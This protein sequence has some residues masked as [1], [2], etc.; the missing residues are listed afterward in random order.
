[1]D[2]STTMRLRREYPL[3]S[4]CVYLNSCSMGAVPRGARTAAARYFDAVEQ[5]RDRVF[6]DLFAEVT[7]Y[8]DG[9]AELIGAA[10]GSVA[11]DV[12]V[13]ALLGRVL[14]ALPWS[15]RPRAITTDLE[16]PSVRFL[17]NAFRRYGCEPHVVPSRDGVTIDVERVVEAI[18]ERTRVVVL[19]HVT[20]ATGALVDVAPI[21]ARA[22]E[23]GALVVLDA[24]QSIG[25]VPVDVERMGV[26]VVLGGAHKWLC[27]A[28]DLAFAWVEPSLLAT[29]EPAAT[30]W[31]ASRDPL[32]FAHAEGWGEGA[33]RL[34]AGTPALVPAITSREGLRLVRELGASA[35]RARSLAMTARIFDHADV[36]GIQTLTP[37]AD[38]ARG[39]VVSLRVPD[40]ARAVADL[41]AA[42]FVCSYRN[43]LR[44]A[45][46]FYNTDDEIDAM[47][48]AVVERARKLS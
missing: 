27:G 24:Y 44:L 18:D 47:M 23:R 12:S 39:G 20:F 8:A 2:A 42:G 31:M 43:G 17:L 32:S 22:R 19:S 16:F 14:S 4:G 33:Q 5:W 41:E 3:L 29:L 1:M 46:H 21:V 15:D 11:L 30:G 45:P 26:D 37:R 28:F 6:G 40:G 25:V 38:D 7:E 9:I 36:A 10:R 48:A 34:A 35:I 13:S